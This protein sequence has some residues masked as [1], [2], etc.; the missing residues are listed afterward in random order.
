MNESAPAKKN[1]SLRKKSAARLAAVQCLYQ[2]A[3]TGQNAKPAQMVNAYRKHRDEDEREDVKTLAKE[4]P[5]DYTVLTK[6]LTAVIDYAEPIDKVVD[7]CITPAWRKERMSPVLL[8]ILRAG[9]AEL[10][11]FPALKPAIIVSEYVD[12]A[13]RFLGDKEVA[14]VNAS[15][16]AVAPSLRRLDG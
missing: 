15:L 10:A 8:A 11:Y 4:S 1:M 7:Q 3:L 9:I 5:P 13:G 6:L 12:I 16:N 2:A 14:F